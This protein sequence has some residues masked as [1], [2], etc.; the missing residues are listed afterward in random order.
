MNIC[1]I[2]NNLTSLIVSKILIN[3][4]AKIDFLTSR[5]NKYHLSYRTIGI[6]KSNI[7]F[8]NNNICSLKN[9]NF[10][11]IN[12][13]K[14]YSDNKKEILEF[15]DNKFLFS[16]FK[17]NDLYKLLIDSLLKNKS[18]RL[19]FINNNFLEKELKKKTKYDLVINCEKNNFLNKK[20]FSTNVKKNYDNLAYTFLLHHKKINNIIARQVFTN[21]GPLAFL[22]LNQT[23]TSI[24]FSYYGLDSLKDKY[25]KNLVTKYNLNIE[26]K[27]F[28]NFEKA[29][30][31]FS[32]A[33]KY[34]KNEILNFGDLLHQIHPLAG[35]GFNMTLRDLKIFSHL[36]KRNISLGL[37]VDQFLLSEFENSVK[38][39]NTIFSFSV[40][41]IYNLFK[42]KKYFK[43]DKIDNLIKLIGQN[44]NIKKQM[45]K[46]ADKGLLI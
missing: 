22:P 7:E 3:N 34:H 41:A 27:K 28:S 20:Y 37:P 25:L 10:K 44:N 31:K 39:K 42:I 29:Y 45:I 21:N 26:I 12:K 30:L 35:Q 13:I 8:I 11:K 1:I 32:S 14:I 15:Q 23:T 19:K 6:S 33:R 46:F 5:F 16:V 9:L 36:I 17:S 38:P 24:V 40:N 43:S 18:F 2:G 4:G